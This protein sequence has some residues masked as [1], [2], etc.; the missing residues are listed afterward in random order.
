MSLDR[1]LY[2][3]KPQWAF[4]LTDDAFIASTSHDELLPGNFRLNWNESRYPE[5]DELICIESP[6]RIRCW[7][8]MNDWILE[9]TVGSIYAMKHSDFEEKY[10]SL[11]SLTT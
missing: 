1:H 6:K 11:N 4:Q 5:K 9:S 10:L 2:V 3:S 8:R 7:V